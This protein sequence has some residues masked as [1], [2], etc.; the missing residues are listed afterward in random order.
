MGLEKPEAQAVDEIVERLIKPELLELAPGVKVIVRGGP[1]GSAFSIKN[2]IAEYDDKP[3]RRKGTAKAGT[4]Q[5][6]IDHTNRFSDTDS[7][8]FASDDPSK[9]KLTTVFDYNR[10][11]AEADPRFGG[12]RTVYDFPFSEEWEAWIE[13]DGPDNAM[14]QGGFAEFLESH[15]VDVAD[16]STAVGSAKEWAEKLGVTFASASRLIELGRNLSITENS[17]LQQATNIGSGEVQFSFVTEHRDEQGQTLKMPGAF[18]L[19]LRVFRGGE[20]F[21]VAARLRYRKSGSSILFFYELWRVDKVFE[22]AFG[23]ACTKAAA[24][25]KLPLFVGSPEV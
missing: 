13:K 23:D 14:S 8:I 20:A 9:P 16:P 15:A 22:T 3:E 19:H 1:N 25:T 6:F 12:H 4:L 10:A 2:L 5:S 17:K 21:Q 24:E 7:A 18:L 11:G